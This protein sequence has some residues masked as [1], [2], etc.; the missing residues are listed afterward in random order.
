MMWEI[1]KV[2]AIPKLNNPVLIEGMPG[3]GNVGKIAEDFLIDDLKA[4][5]AYDFFSYNFPH[6]VF[7]NEDNLVELP[8]IGLYY[9][10][11]NDKRSDLLLLGGDIQ[12]VSEG[13]C[14]E[15]C[16]KV[17]DII[18]KNNV[19]EIITLG[20][21]G[22]QSAPKKPKVYCTGN[23]KEIIKKYK[24]GVDVEDKIYGTVGPIIGVSGVLLGMAKRR[25]I[26]A[27]TFLAET[28]GHP[29]HI[30]IKESQEIL[31]V[32]D[33]KLKL[34]LNLKKLEKDIND[35]EK[36]MLQRTKN[37]SE[38]IKQTSLKGVKSRFK[39]TNYIG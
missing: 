12:P 11:F 16:D 7:V 25:N 9:K 15:F 24:E 22:L 20:G 2:A 13:S 28:F 33:K 6:S 38:A 39:D 17:L 35:L 8:K 3:I 5:K 34:G 26:N 18:E 14:F 36:E 30:G 32:L 1:K 27:V 19:K 23:S 31:K 21:I 37:L 10:K 4:K 29:M